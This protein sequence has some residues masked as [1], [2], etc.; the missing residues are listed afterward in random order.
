MFDYYH[1]KKGKISTKPNI[2]A[3]RIHGDFI[4]E[5]ASIGT[6]LHR[7]GRPTGTINV[8]MLCPGNKEHT[9]NN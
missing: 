8:P 1:E 9:R 2:N 4:W 3:R 7:N 6:P 5:N